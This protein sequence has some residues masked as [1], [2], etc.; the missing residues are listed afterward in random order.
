MISIRRKLMARAASEPAPEGYEYLEY[1][2][3]QGTGAVIQIPPEYFQLAIDDIINIKMSCIN[4][5][6][7]QC[8]AGRSGKW[9]VEIKSWN[10]DQT[11]GSFGIWGGVIKTSPTSNECVVNTI[12]NLVYQVVGGVV[13]NGVNIGA[14]NDS[15]GGYPFYGRFYG[16]SFARAGQTVLNMIPAKRLSDGKIGM[17][18]TVQGV[19]FSST[20]GVEFEEPQI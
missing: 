3:K 6:G 1:I 16:V 13:S 17:Y 10:A 2:Q 8:F 5:V 20:S 14:Y 11:V 4:G 9:D 18:E 7:Y 15:G 19:F 12:Y